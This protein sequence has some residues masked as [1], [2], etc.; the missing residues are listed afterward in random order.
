MIHTHGS[1]GAIVDL[2]G[3]IAVSIL[4]L[5]I[6]LNEGLIMKLLTD[7][8]SQWEQTC[9]SWRPKLQKRKVSN[10]SWYPYILILSRI[11]KY[12]LW[13]VPKLQM[14]PIFWWILPMHPTVWISSNQN[15]QAMLTPVP[16]FPNLA[17]EFTCLHSGVGLNNAQWLGMPYFLDKGKIPNQIKENRSD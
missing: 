10:I 6:W 17:Q 5:G 2:L 3:C 14:L 4:N 16:R 9:C 8:K 12:R 13:S 1:K 11:M 7:N 15:R